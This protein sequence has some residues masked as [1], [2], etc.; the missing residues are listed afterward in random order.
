[1]EFGKID[2]PEGIDFS[3]PS[4]HAANRSMLAGLQPARGLLYLGLTGWGE[5]SW[6]GGLYPQGT[7]PPQFLAQ[8]ACSFN[9]VELNSTFYGLPTAR[10]LTQWL[11]ATPE[12]FRFFPKVWKL[13]SHRSDLGMGSQAWKTYADMAIS[14]G[15]RHG[16]SFLQLPPGHSEA[17]E[18]GLLRFL[19]LWPEGP[20]LY[21][22]FRDTAWLESDRI[23]DILEKKACGLVITDTP[24]HRELLHMRLTV[25]RTIVRFVASGY[26]A[27]DE[28]RI[29]DW[30]IRL[31]DWFESGLEEAAFFCHEPDNGQAPS[32]AQR[33][34]KAFQDH[35]LTAIPPI[36][37]ILDHASRQGNL[38][39]T[40]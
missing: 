33:C 24:G 8:Y 21:L 26:P 36:P 7:K 12:S 35:D 32:L 25:P 3:L 9:S 30:G 13:I 31:N 11:E 15:T 5:R 39:A 16:G 29:G 22:E 19:D 17:R 40:A 20:R 4:D 28:L 37:E 18:S 27:I 2:S 1:M 38:F 6:A 14:M 34:R 23:L 10:T